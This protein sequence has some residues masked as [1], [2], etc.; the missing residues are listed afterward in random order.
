MSHYYSGKSI[1][2]IETSRKIIMQSLNEGY[3]ELREHAPSASVDLFRLTE[4]GREC[5]KL[6]MDFDKL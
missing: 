4:K 1:E 5:I 2:H 3:I 6:R